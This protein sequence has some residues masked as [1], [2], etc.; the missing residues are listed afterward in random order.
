MAVGTGA[1]AAGPG[2][3]SLRRALALP[4]TAYP[5]RGGPGTAW[6]V[7]RGWGEEREREASCDQNPTS[8]M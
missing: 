3:S 7:S 4:R 8:G 6:G 5:G 2:T 1:P